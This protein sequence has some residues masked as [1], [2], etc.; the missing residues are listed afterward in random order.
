MQ[1]TEVFR[2]ALK[3]IVSN[4]V[5]AILTMLG[6][7]IGVS[8]VILLVA[9]GQG[10]QLYI[11]QQFES[12]GAN[13]VAV[14]PGTVS[15]ENGLSGSQ[16]NFAGSKLTLKM[17]NDI[18]NLG[19]PI[20]AAGGA[21]QIPTTIQYKGK[22]KYTTIAGI[23][24]NYSDIRNLTTSTGR[25]ISQSDVDSGRNVAILGESIR[26]NLFGQSDSIGKEVTIADNKYT[27]IGI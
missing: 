6:I 13:T 20:E 15:L 18:N 21:S 27:V 17:A 5:R 11:T 26:E 25:N 24:A 22:S 1:L 4:K 10:L 23:T 2:L 14:L 9:V 8:C 3:S 7:I 12:L 19:G 16:P